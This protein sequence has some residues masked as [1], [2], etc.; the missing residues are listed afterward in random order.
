MA[1]SSELTRNMFKSTSRADV[2]SFFVGAVPRVR[3]VRP[4]EASVGVFILKV[5]TIREKCLRF[6]IWKFE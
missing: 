4:A 2:H 6:S 1:A 3:S 5:D